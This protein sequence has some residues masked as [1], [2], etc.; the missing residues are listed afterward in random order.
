MRVGR[1]EVTALA[2]ERVLR[3]QLLTPQ[4]QPSTR[5][6][7]DTPIQRLHDFWTAP[8]K[9]IIGVEDLELG[10]EGK[11]CAEQILLVPRPVLLENP[12]WRVLETIEHIVEV[13]HHSRVEA[14]QDLKEFVVNIAACFAYVSRV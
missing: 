10:V 13:D 11:E 4:P 14:G 5:I 6:S 12:L 9:S 3:G 8:G 7:E 2:R 1:L